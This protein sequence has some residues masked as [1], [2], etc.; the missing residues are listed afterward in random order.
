MGELYGNGENT[1]E[2]S[3]GG[4]TSPGGFSDAR[5]PNTG[6][7]RWDD[8]LVESE[9]MS[10]LES[11]QYISPLFGTGDNLELGS[12]V[13]SAT[14]YDGETA[15]TLGLPKKRALGNA[16][17][18]QHGGVDSHLFFHMVKLQKPQEALKQPW[19]KRVMAQI[20]GASQPRLPMPWL[21]LP[22]VGR[23]K[24]FDGR[25]SLGRATGEESP[26]N[27]FSLQTLV[28]NS[29]GSNR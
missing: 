9:Q 21:A 29:T 18:Q 8:S 26:A 4:Q 2:A 15:A 20:C 12:E 17:V 10:F 16:L 5:G 1:V 24:Q 25:H 19:E 23:R 22:S 28:N 11:G 14:Y 3:P 13:P 7:H 6:L 27:T